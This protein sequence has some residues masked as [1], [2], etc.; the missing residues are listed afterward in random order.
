MFK[1]EK[2]DTVT[3]NYIGKLADGTLFDSSEGKEPLKFI[4]GQQEVIAGFDRAVVGMVTGEKKT[5]TVSPDDGYGPYHEKLVETVER[6]LLP[7]DLELVVG[8]QLEVTREDGHV[9]HF[10][11]ND[12]SDSTVTLDANHPLAGKELTFEISMLNVQK[13]P[14]A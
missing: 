9:M 1:A 11:I 2:G 8:G 6:S 7:D 10:F 5:V 12:L 14:T 4:I 13:H 3:V